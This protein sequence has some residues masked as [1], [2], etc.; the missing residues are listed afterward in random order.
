M[1]RVRTESAAYRCYMGLL[2]CPCRCMNAHNQTKR[3]TLVRRILSMTC[4]LQS[5]AVGAFGLPMPLTETLNI[6]QHGSLTRVLTPND[7]TG[8][9]RCTLGTAGHRHFAPCK[10]TVSI[11]NPIFVC[12]SSCPCVDSALR[13]DMN[14]S[15]NVTQ[16]IS[17]AKDV[18][19][20][21]MLECVVVSALAPPL[22]PPDPEKKQ[23]KDVNLY[24]THKKDI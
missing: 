21:T 20:N 3:T 13:R 15:N 4:L 24:T 19:E 11:N 6:T 12:L 10:P 1:L 23:N 14:D 9:R 18:T 8:N 22:S 2:A 17:K 5:A 16:Q 7:A